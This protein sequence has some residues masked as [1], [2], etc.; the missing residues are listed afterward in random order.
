MLKG[1]TWSIEDVFLERLEMRAL[2]PEAL[3]R[4]WV[5]S[6]DDIFGGVL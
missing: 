5:P 4:E 2:V 6:L 3:E 1:K